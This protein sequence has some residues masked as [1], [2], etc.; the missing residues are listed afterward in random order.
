MKPRALIIPAAIR[1]HVLPSLY[2]ADVLAD[3]YEVYY[4]VTNQVLAEIVEKNG[5]QA[6]MNS[7]QKVGYNMEASFLASKKQKL[8]YLR[9]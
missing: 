8:S 2:V 3:E 1:S 6:L 9:L 7:G 5:Y 4:A